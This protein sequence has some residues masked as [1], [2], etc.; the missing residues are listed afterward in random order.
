MNL[1]LRRRLK[2]YIGMDIKEEQIDLMTFAEI[3]N[4]E[5]EKRKNSKFSWETEI[6]K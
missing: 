6:K 1:N 4:L 3:T 5:H 2:N